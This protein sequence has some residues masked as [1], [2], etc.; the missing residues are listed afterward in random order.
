[1]AFSRRSDIV[2]LDPT[3]VQEWVSELLLG[4]VI[5][6]AT[7][8][9]LAYDT[10]KYT[11]RYPNMPRYLTDVK[12]PQSTK[13]YVLCRFPTFEEDNPFSKTG[14]ILLG[15]MSTL[16][17]LI[18]MLMCHEAEEGPLERCECCLFRSEHRYFSRSVLDICSQSNRIDISDSSA[19]PPIW[20]VSSF[21]SHQHL[22]VL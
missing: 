10:S 6:V 8:T 1:M 3:K 19:P 21:F 13:K 18:A 20:F 4:Q 5:Q 17:S 14:Q 16:Q 9:V 22:E 2:P 7:V 11:I 15:M 12:S